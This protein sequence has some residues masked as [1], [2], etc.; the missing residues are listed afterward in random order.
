MLKYKSDSKENEDFLQAIDKL[1]A[2]E[3]S[4]IFV[5]VQAL[6]EG[7]EDILDITEQ[8]QGKYR[9]GLGSIEV[10]YTKEADNIIITSIVKKEK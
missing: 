2:Q 1:K 4:M 7:K 10:Y 8:E 3:K 9:L 5:A 6:G